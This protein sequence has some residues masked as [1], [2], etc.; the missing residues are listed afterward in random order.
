MQRLVPRLRV[1]IHKMNN[2]RRRALHI[3]TEKIDED[4]IDQS[5]IP[6]CHPEGYSTPDCT[7]ISR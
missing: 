7:H 1:I 4:V 2:M 6:F 5:F 3:K